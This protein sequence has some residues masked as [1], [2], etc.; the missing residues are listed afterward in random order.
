MKLVLVSKHS[1][2]MFIQF[3]WCEVVTGCVDGSECPGVSGGG[4]YSN[5]EHQVVIIKPQSLGP[6][7]RVG[8]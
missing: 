8:I 2:W 7:R 4:C 3:A 1:S 6:R 5:A